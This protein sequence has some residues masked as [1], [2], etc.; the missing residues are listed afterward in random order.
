M[1]ADIHSISIPVPRR[2]PTH[3]KFIISTQQNPL[4]IIGKEFP[5]NRG[6]AGKVF[7][8]KKAEY[9]TRAV[10]HPDHFNL[11]DKEAKTQTGKGAMLTVPLVFQGESIG[12]IQFM[13]EP[14]SS[15]Q[16]GVV[17][18]SL[19]YIDD[20]SQKLKKLQDDIEIDR[21]FRGGLEQHETTVFFTDINDYSSV[22][23]DMSLNQ[24]AELLN[25]YYCRTVSHAVQ[26]G[27]RFEEY[28]GDG[29]YLSFHHESKAEQVAQALKC[30]VE[31][32]ETFSD[33]LKQWRTY[34][35]TIT[36]SNF[37]NI[38]ISCGMVHELIVGHELYRKRK[39][40]SP[41]VDTAAHL[42]E[43]GKNH[44]GCILVCP[45]TFDLYSG[46]NYVFSKVDGESERTWYLLS[47]SDDT[48]RLGANGTA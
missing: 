13:K 12:V 23:K 17:E 32:Q 33:L 45:R 47:K 29:V 6:I 8:S 40:V 48:P 10:D 22:V 16:E 14:G 7:H 25:E 5:I 41:V 24:T 46:K 4:E 19:R 2:S 35:Y 11:I 27:A 31:M 39:L 3:L 38:G 34:G 21:L 37:H 15:F 30:A 20:I 18:V 28:L 36:E 42:V 43:E 44:G 9:V 1:G 26:N